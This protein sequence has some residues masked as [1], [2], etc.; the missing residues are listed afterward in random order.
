MTEINSYRIIFGFIQYVWLATQEAYTVLYNITAS[1]KLVLMTTYFY[2]H[3]KQHL[4]Q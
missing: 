3:S 1:E 2:R 4:F